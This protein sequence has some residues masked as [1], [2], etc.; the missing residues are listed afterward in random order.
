MIQLFYF[1]QFSFAQVK[2]KWIQVLL[3]ITNNSIK[4]QS[5]VYS[6]L[7]VKT[8]QFQAIQFRINHLLA[9]SVNDRV[10]R[11]N[12][13]QFI[14]P[15]DKTLSGA[16]TPGQNVT[17]SDGI[18]VVLHILQGSS[19]T[20]AFPSDCLMSYLRC[21]LELSYSSA[22]MKSVCFTAPADWAK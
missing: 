22:A 1:K 16:N 9:H 3:C 6:Q 18:E 19:I 14:W 8:D 15:I 7:N 10:Y 5:S 4:H 13:K 2:V 20:R 21:S 11:L 12:V 17:G